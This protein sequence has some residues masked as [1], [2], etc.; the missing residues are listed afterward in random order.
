[1]KD[2]L[3]AVAIATVMKK[4]GKLDFEAAHRIYSPDAAESTHKVAK[5]TMWNEDV[6][7]ELERLL[8]VRDKDLL[9]KL[10]PEVIVQ[11]LLEDLR[12]LNELVK[13]NKTDWE[14]VVKLLMAKGVKQKLIG[15]AI[16]IW[17]AEKPQEREKSAGE[18]FKEL[19]KF[20]GRN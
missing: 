12:M 8:R 20:G 1:M 11:D 4:T 15:M 3:K 13:S 9:K 6:M 5:R 19:E 17:K 10:T 7:D 14:A 18:L 2:K 16:G